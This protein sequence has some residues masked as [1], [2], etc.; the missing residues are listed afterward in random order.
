MQDSRLRIYKLTEQKT[1]EYLDKIQK[2]EDKVRKKRLYDYID[3]K[4]KELLTKIVL[5]KI[6]NGIP[7]NETTLITIRIN[8][9]MFFISIL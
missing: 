7:S 2:I 1:D 8:I 4:I 5:S 3:V 6:A 9:L